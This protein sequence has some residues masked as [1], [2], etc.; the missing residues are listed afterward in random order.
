MVMQMLKDM[1]YL[2]GDFEINM[3]KQHFISKFGENMKRE[4][5]VIDKFKKNDNSDQIY[6]FFPEE[7][8]VGVKTMKTNI[9]LQQARF[10][11]QQLISGV[12]YCHSMQICHRDLKLENNFLDGSTTPRVKI[13]DFGYSKSSVLHSQP[14]SSVGTPAY[15]ALEVL[16]RKEFDGKIADVWSC[17]ATLYVMLVG[18][19]PFEDP[20]TNGSQFFITTVTTS[21]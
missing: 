12:S 6:V 8:K 7:A 19:Y 18:A 20:D 16:S 4:D 2:I 9:D 17:G 10:F 1:G 14:K 13:C 3:S 21:W 15:I 5:L 11:F